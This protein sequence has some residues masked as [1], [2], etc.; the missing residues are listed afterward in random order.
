M[1]TAHTALTGV[2]RLLLTDLYS[3]YWLGTCR[4]VKLEQLDGT[5]EQKV[6]W[7]W[8][9][10]MTVSEQYDGR[11]TVSPGERISVPKGRF[12]RQRWAHGQWCG[13][14]WAPREP[15]ELPWSNRNRPSG[16]RL[17][18]E[19]WRTEHAPLTC[20]TLSRYLISKSNLLSVRS[21]THTSP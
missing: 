12:V 18:A 2:F 8:D 16:W 13:L 17:T 19:G 7:R 3:R 11:W 21:R 20:K 9:E 14:G 10:T 5:W 15:R 4:D 1:P 6:W